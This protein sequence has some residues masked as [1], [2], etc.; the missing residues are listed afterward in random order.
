MKFPARLLLVAASAAA[1]AAACAAPPRYL[2][3]AFA[4]RLA[5]TV[6]AELAEQVSPRKPFTAYHSHSF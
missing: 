3:V 5:T 1:Y 4:P 6:L 2:S